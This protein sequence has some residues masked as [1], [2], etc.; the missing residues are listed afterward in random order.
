MKY[1]R[2]RILAAVLSL[3]GSISSAAPAKPPVPDLT[4]GGVKDDCHD[5]NLGPTGLRGWIWGW[6]LQTTD[7]RQILVTAVAQGSP[8]EGVLRVGDVILGVEGRAFESDARIAFAKALT[9]AEAV[10]G[11]LA[12]MVWRDGANIPADL[13]LAVLGG[14]SETAPYNCAKSQRIL[15]QGCRHIGETGFKNSRGKVEI[16]IPNALAALALLASGRQEYIPLVKEYAAAV[17]EHTP[18]GH[19]SWG[20]AYQS[21]FLAE[22][23]LATGDKTVMPGLTRLATAIAGGTSGVGTWGHSFARPEDKILNG[24]GCMNQPGIVLALAMLTA[25]EA[26]VKSP[27]LNKAIALSARFLGWFAGKGAIPYGD[28]APWPEHD[29]NG[30]CSS[31]ALMFNLLGERESAAFFARMALA[32]HAERECGHTGNFFNVLWALPGVALSGEKAAAAYFEQTAW[33]YDLA[34]GWNGRFHHQ[35]LPGSQRENYHPWDVTGAYLLTYAL[36]LRTLMITGGKPACFKPLTD[37]E[38]AQTIDD[39]RWAWWDGQE[40]YYDSLSG[41]ELAPGLT[42]WSPTVR[43]RTAAALAKRG[44]IKIAT[45]IKLLDEPRTETRYGACVLLRCLGPQADPAAARLIELLDSADP[46]MRALSAEALAEMSQPVRTAALPALLKAIQHKGCAAD[47][48]RCAMGPLSEVLFKPSPG[49]RTPDSILRNSLDLLNDDARPLLLDAL[50]TVLSSEDGRIRSAAGK[51]Y[52]LLTPAELAR[53]M[54]DIEKSIRVPAPSG[55]MF[56]YGIRMDGLELLAKLHIREGMNLCVDIMNERR[57]GRDFKRTARILKSYQGAAQ[58]VL[59]RLKNETRLI[60]KGEDKNRPEQLEQLIRE[61]ENFTD[62]P[63]LRGINEFT[64]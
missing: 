35:G 22:Y 55:E 30:K 42:S 24:Y 52:P 18:G 62:A 7:A 10:R 33:Y 3:A 37:K 34:R 16:N 51:I 5:W 25:R 9:R 32:A 59:P 21:L 54:P 50:R 14:Y 20:Y 6:R 44:G 2:Y 1:A 63:E 49:R 15:E 41:P 47:P 29:D 17:A 28:H 61:I 13:N 31:G 38:V 40:K 43:S 56:A 39:G 46:W 26:G 27:E 64:G 57:W 8:A 4:G 12:L 60:I 45:V 36:P 58:A 19:I 48:R 23:A 53:L 11:D